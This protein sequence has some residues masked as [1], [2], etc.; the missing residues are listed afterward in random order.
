MVEVRENIIL[1]FTCLIINE[2]FRNNNFLDSAAG[3]ML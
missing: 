1:F 2:H 3:N